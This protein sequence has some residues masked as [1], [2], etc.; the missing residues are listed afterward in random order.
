[1]EYMHLMWLTRRWI[2][3]T[4]CDFSLFPSLLH[5]QIPDEMNGGQHPSH[6]IMTSPQ[7]R[8]VKEGIYT[9]HSLAFLQIFGWDTCVSYFNDKESDKW[10]RKLGS[11]VITLRKLSRINYKDSWLGVPLK[12]RSSMRW[13]SISQDIWWCQEDSCFYHFSWLIVPGQQGDQSLWAEE[14]ISDLEVRG[15]AVKTCRGKF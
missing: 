3:K 4:K 15:Q 2:P 14:L 11:V 13:S 10:D 8:V 7:A 6:P 1:M 9:L 5:K 12:V